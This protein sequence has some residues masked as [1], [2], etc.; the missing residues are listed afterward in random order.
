MLLPSGLSVKIPLLPPLDKMSITVIATLLL[1]WMKGPPMRHPRQSALIYFFGAAFLLSPIFT[2]LGNS[3]ELLTPKE[4]IPGFYPLDGVKY[5]GRNLL[6]LA[7]FHL[8]SRFLS[9]DNARALLL[10]YLP[11]AALVYSLP[12]LFEL[13]MA[14]QLHTWVY[15]YFPGDAFS[16]Q[17]RGPVVFFEHGLALALFI[18]L[19]FVASLVLVRM[20]ARVFHVPAGAAAAYLGGLLVVACKSLGPIIYAGAVAPLVLF[21][22]PRLWVKVSFAICLVVCAYPALRNNGLA[23]TQLVSDFASRISIERSKSFD[24]RVTN[25]E[26][27]L[28]KANQKPY[29]GWGTWG[30]NRIYDKDTGKDISI[31]D[32]GWIIEYGTFGW[33][34]YLSLFGLLAAAA[35]QPLRKIDSKITPANV[36]LAGLTLLLGI[37]VVDQ[38]PNADP[39]SRG[40]A[41]VWPSSSLASRP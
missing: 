20:K 2:S 28:A 34:G 38:I 30:R 25:E 32:G 13:R 15:G 41:L 18:C 29:F 17:I 12:M 26:Q 40:G 33:F 9:S 8:G 1:C 6:M 19:T 24:T 36:S 21:T 3:Y 10:K 35:F 39:F 37:Y 27:L 31:T 22:R 7:P 5:A 11:A 23:P 16:Q 14:P 4:S